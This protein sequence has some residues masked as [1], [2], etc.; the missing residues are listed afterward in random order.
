M[1]REKIVDREI[2]KLRQAARSTEADL[3]KARADADIMHKANHL[4]WEAYTKM[5][6]RKWEIGKIRAGRRKLFG[7]RIESTCDAISEYETEANRLYHAPIPEREYIDKSK[8]EIWRL[9]QRITEI[10]ERGWQ[11][12]A[13]SWP[14]T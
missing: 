5:L 2:E 7:E 3:N 6:H 1:D 8:K 11:E 14:T 13:P 10:K 9:K 4:A 12:D